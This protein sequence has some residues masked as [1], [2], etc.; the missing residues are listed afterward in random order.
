MRLAGLI[1]FSP[2]L[3]FSP[4]GADITSLCPKATQR[5][6]PALPSAP[7]LVCSKFSRSMERLM[8]MSS[9][10]L[11]CQC[12]AVTIGNGIKA[13]LRF[14]FFVI[15]VC[16]VLDCL[17]FEDPGIPLQNPDHEKPEMGHF[18]PD[19][20]S[21][22]SSGLWGELKILEICPDGGTGMIFARF[23]SSSSEICPDGVTGLVF[24]SN[25]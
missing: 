14:G 15:A 20:F 3:A 9:P 5:E 10:L 2:K 22:N 21:K 24:S 13:L 12:L 8:Q 18:R 4:C 23:S 7:N 11:A 6:V 1:S 17:L 16:T 25:V 19:R